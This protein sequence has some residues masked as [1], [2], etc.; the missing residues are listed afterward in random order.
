VPEL[1]DAVPEDQMRAIFAM[2]V[3]SQDRGMTVAA[4]RAAVAR[5]FNVSVEEVVRA[6]HIGIRE[7]WPPL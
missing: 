5:R 7:Q 3:E 1:P 6:E 4:S 2:L